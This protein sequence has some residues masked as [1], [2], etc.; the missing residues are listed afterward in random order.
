MKIKKIFSLFLMVLLS[1]I[2]ICL[3]LAGGN[4][5]SAD[6][7]SETTNQVVAKLFESYYNNG[8]YTKDT[9]IYANVDAMTEDAL[10]LG[11]TAAKFFHAGHIP[12][13]ERTTEYTP[14]RLLMTTAS[15]QDGVGYKD[16]GD[17][18]VRF[19]VVDGVD[20][21][22]Y[23]VKNTSV[24][25]Y[26]VTLEDFAL[27]SV[28]NQYSDL[29]TD[30][31]DAVW[32]D[33]GDLYSTEDAEVIDAF[34]LFT[35]PMWLGK[36]AKIEN[37]LIY[38]KATV[39][40]VERNLVMKLWVSSGDY[41]KIITDEE[42]V[43]GQS[44]VFSEA[45]ISSDIN[46]GYTISFNSNGGTSVADV[47]VSEGET[48]SAP[49]SSKEGY[50][51]YGWY[52]EGNDMEEF[53][54]SRPITSNVTLEALWGADLGS[55][56]EFS[57]IMVTRKETGLE[58]KAYNAN[59]KS[60]DIFEVY[61][62][63]P[64]FGTLGSS[65]NNDT[66]FV[67]FRADGKTTIKRFPNNKAETIYE[68]MDVSSIWGVSSKVEGN[69]IIGFLPYSVMGGVSTL[70][71]NNPNKCE[72]F[73]AELITKETEVGL[74]LTTNINS[75]PNWNILGMQSV[76]GNPTTYVYLTAD[77]TLSLTT[78]V[79]DLGSTRY[80]DL[81]AVR[82]ENGIE[83]TAISANP[84]WQLDYE[85]VA[86]FQGSEVDYFQVYYQLPKIA[87]L[88]SSRTKDT[89][90]VTF[91]A[92]ETAHLHECSKGT[93]TLKYAMA[94]CKAVG[95]TCERRGNTLV[96]FIPYSVMGE[97]VDETYDIGLSMVGLR[98]KENESWPN[99]AVT[100]DGV[101]HTTNR[102]NPS[103]Y[104]YYLASNKLSLTTEQSPN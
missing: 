95:I 91:Y 15:D 2:S 42:L 50:V 23:T 69:T 96:G 72:L 52:V 57:N 43:E 25:S 75:W 74:S 90:A 37:Y 67:D 1:I 24:E 19:E 84:N 66:H 76:R 85:G 17:D 71:S 86:N 97:G 8:T 83:F 34:R 100:I 54:F 21:N 26:Y 98:A 4:I 88:G 30:I 78:K 92:T 79:V 102:S 6:V 104:V 10:E 61:Y 103:T 13:L 73:N 62:Q 89:Y 56:G 55:I 46:L 5:V 38:T 7:D 94:Q 77:S 59:L 41:G 65:R 64:I 28:T 33:E 20:K 82:K 87:T 45:I 70:V 31:S 16:D 39:E 3:F 44:Y 18:M 63:L 80:Y 51:L 48:I 11:E 49:V 58:F 81:T 53:D 99:W 40:V 9:I 12:A 101:S 68:N 60:T 29:A 36:T 22:S 27:Q 47:V 35:A 93:P 32:N 14:G